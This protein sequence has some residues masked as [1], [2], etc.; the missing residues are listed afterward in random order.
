[1]TYR[2]C[3]APIKRWDLA[4]VKQD[5]NPLNELPQ[6]FVVNHVIEYD[7]DFVWKK[8]IINL[9][10][11]G[12]EILKPQIRSVHR[13]VYVRSRFLGSFGARSKQCDVFDF[14]FF[15]KQI[16]KRLLN[17]FTKCSA[18]LKNRTS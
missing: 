12:K 10:L 15:R 6:G 1:M 17:G 3:I 9:A 2:D 11:N 4:L 13:Q 7:I 14:N 8:Q 18:P 5:P 16:L